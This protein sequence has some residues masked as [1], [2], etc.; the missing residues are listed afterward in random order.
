MQRGLIRIIYQWTILV[1]LLTL[2][3][4]ASVS[5]A[6]GQEAEHNFRRAAILVRNAHYEEALALLEEMTATCD[7]CT[8]AKLLIAKS[9]IGL[10]RDLPR[11]EVIL[12]FQAP[13]PETV[14]LTAEVLHLQYRFEEARAKY[15][16]YL[17]APD[18]A[19]LSQ[20]ETQQ[21]MANCQNGQQMVNHAFRPYCFSRVKIARD[22]VLSALSGSEQ[23]YSILPLPSALAGPFDQDTSLKTTLVAYP[24]EIVAGTRIIFPRRSSIRGTRDLYIIE[25][26]EN[27]LWSR[28]A[29]LSPVIN[30]PHD[31]SFGILSADG[32]TLF[33]NSNGLYGMGKSDI[34]RSEYDAVTQQW[35]APENLGFPYNT[36]FNDYILQLPNEGGRIVI[37]SDR[38]CSQDSLQLYTLHYDQQQAG[39]PLS[40]L[41]SIVSASLF[42]VKAE[43]PR[44]APEAAAQRSTARS[45][46]GKQSLKFRDV[47]GDP[48]YQA[49]LSKGFAQQRLA[50][51]LRVDLEAL[52]ERLWDA[53]TLA[54]RQNIEGKIV[55]VERSMLQ[56]QK[57]ADE[58]FVRASQ[59]EQEYITGKRSLLKG[60]N[61]EGAFAGDAPTS[62]YQAQLASTVFQTNEIRELA[63]AAQLQR[64]MM[65]EAQEI[66]RLQQAQMMRLADTVATIAEISIAER[67]LESLSSAFTKRYGS[68]VESMRRIYSQCLAVALMKSDRKSATLVMAAEGKARELYR[69]AETL[70]N[71]A[72]PESKGQSDFSALM[73]EVMGNDYL[74][75]GFTYT[76]SMEAYRQ[77]V[78]KRIAQLSPFLEVTFG[79][80]SLSTSTAKS[81]STPD[82]EPTEKPI[83]DIAFAQAKVEGLEIISPPPYNDANPVPRDAPLPRGVVYRL[84]LGAYSNPIDPVL[85]QGMTPINAETVSGGK[86]TKYYAG[87]FRRRND[88]EK[89]RSITTS[90]GFPDA[91][92]VAWHNGRS[93][94]LARAQA[95]EAEEPTNSAPV[96]VEKQVEVGSFQV[97]IGY[98]EDSLPEHIRETLSILAPGR[99]VMRRAEEGGK[100]VYTVGGFTTRG[101]AE[102]L[103]DNL[104]ASGLIEAAVEE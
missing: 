73:L 94:P 51:S 58:H 36:P 35:S 41:N 101:Q 82:N 54:Q 43:R 42:E 57:R 64:P 40:D 49:E 81:A 67:Q 71:N 34:F 56:A 13:S 17:Q 61:G 10:H 74:E 62:L 97:R 86:I 39:I 89:G 60:R 7:T 98:F 80:N 78:E 8:A 53:R 52:R 24:K 28:P 6:F 91:F 100:W 50:D 102:R 29:L 26:Q 66:L 103:R 65:A 70:R 5:V 1:G 59:I 48:E 90:C 33:F 16:Q 25:Q 27:G 32:K 99:E 77:S 84:Q 72:A 19:L 63:V 21:R 9:L 12:A 3:Q 11:A 2:G 18:I 87:E 93:I 69:T 31:E 23:R 76:W 45:E 38:N 30:T 96:V 44:I 22:S 92:I 47:E 46:S 37:A 20:A 15:E 75:L 68:S 85:F 88:A 4:V 55:P 104:L 83:G 95:L 79:E 14:L